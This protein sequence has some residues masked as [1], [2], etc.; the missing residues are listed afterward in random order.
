VS[1]FNR[2]VSL[3]LRDA[4]RRVADALTPGALEPIDRYLR[5]SIIV[6][7]IDRATD[8]LSAWWMASS[9]FNRLSMLRAT[10]SDD[11]ALGHRAIALMLLIAVGVNAAL[12]LL[13]GPRPGWFW[14]IIPAMALTF[15]A[16]LFAGSR[17]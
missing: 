14:M 16:L 2:F 8:R 11:A 5:S 6:T 3:G 12:T 17:R 4:D 15:A 1:A 9:V 7:A 13:N 10:R